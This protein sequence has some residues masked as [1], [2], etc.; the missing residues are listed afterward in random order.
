MSERHPVQRSANEGRCIGIV[1]LRWCVESQSSAPAIRRLGMNPREHHPS[2]SGGSLHNGR[3]S[4]WVF[5]NNVTLA[6]KLGAVL[7]VV[8]ERRRS[9]NLNSHRRL[10]NVPIFQGIELEAHT[11]R[12]IES[13]IG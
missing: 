12:E 5:G 11:F 13:V 8:V 9:G 7:P 10:P 4:V 6:R 2:V 1:Y 3:S